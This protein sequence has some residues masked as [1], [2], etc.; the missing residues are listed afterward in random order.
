[1][2]MSALAGLRIRVRPFS[3][4]PGEIAFTRTPLVRPISGEVAREP[5]QRGLDDRVGHGLHWL[6]IGGEPA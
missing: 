6:P 2:G 4:P 1:M 3:T 5:E